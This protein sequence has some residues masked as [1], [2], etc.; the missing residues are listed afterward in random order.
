MLLKEIFNTKEDCIRLDPLS[1]SIIPYSV[2]VG[3]KNEN[4][5]CSDINM[6]KGVAIFNF[7]NSARK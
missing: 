3:V 1:A 6:Q 4:L 2:T 7:E 5:T